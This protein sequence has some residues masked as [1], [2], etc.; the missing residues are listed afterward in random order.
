MQA[1]SPNQRGE[2]A[3]AGDW[4]RM[5]NRRRQPTVRAY[6]A[7]LG[8]VIAYVLSDFG[9]W[10]RLAYSPVRGQWSFDSGNHLETIR[11]WGGIL[12]AVGGA[13]SG[14]V[15]GTIW[16]HLTEPQQPTQPTSLV[17]HVSMLLAGWTLAALV[18]GVVYFIW[19]LWPG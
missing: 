3:N 9:D 8:A 6:C 2:P 11:Y 14:A 5:N 7:M 1:L 15:I 4:S 17:A 12:W 16:E 18:L 13:A 10:P 19:I